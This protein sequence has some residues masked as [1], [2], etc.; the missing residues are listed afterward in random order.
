MNR[1]TASVLTTG[2]ALAL[3]A[4]LSACG[5]DDSGSKKDEGVKG[6]EPTRSSAEPSPSPSRSEKTAERPKI[7]LPG[8]LRY[9]FDWPK[10]GDKKKDAVMADAEQRIKAVDL[11]ISRQDPTDAAYRFYSEGT[12]AAGSED[13]IKLFTSKGNTITGYRH[14]YK[15]VVQLNDDGT[16][17]FVYCE[18]QA[19]AYNKAVKTGKVQKTQPSKNS[20]VVYNTRLRLDDKGVWVTEKLISQR[21]SATCQP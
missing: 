8:D 11:A 2:V 17:G 16:A 15:P 19:T 6:A 4:S 13:F 12:A 10:T 21:G 9:D 20:Y 14:F 3:A 18:D 1:R 5:G 7:E